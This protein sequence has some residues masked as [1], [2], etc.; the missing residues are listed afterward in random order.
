MA[1]RGGYINRNYRRQ[2]N[3]KLLMLLL[4]NSFLPSPV[5]IFKGIQ[6]EIRFGRRVPRQ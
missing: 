2:H 4:W 6:W 3:G 1:E 5:E